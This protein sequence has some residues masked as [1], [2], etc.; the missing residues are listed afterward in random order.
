V[1]SISTTERVAERIDFPQSSESANADSELA[2]T[3]KGVRFAGA[4]LRRPSIPFSAE[5]PEGGRGRDRIAST[6][7]PALS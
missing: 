7:Q 3:P 4:S 6:D 1:A 5:I 2:K